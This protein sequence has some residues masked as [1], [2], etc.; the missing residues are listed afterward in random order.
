ML[1]SSPNIIKLVK[2]RKTGVKD[3]RGT[4][5]DKG[6]ILMAFTYNTCNRASS[7]IKSNDISQKL[8]SNLGIDTKNNNNKAKGVA[9]K[10]LADIKIE[11]STSGTFF[12][13][14]SAVARLNALN[15]E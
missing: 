2:T 14:A 12:V 3:I 5:R 1:G 4:T 6:E 7:G 8:I 10:N 15:N 13:N 9:Y 11:S